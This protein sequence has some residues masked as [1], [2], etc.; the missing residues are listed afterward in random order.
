MTIRGVFFDVDFTLIRPGMMFQGEGYEAF[1]V[2]H[3]I[4]VDRHKFEEALKSAAPLLDG[5]E[6][7]RYDA[8]I[9]VRYTRHIIEQMGGSGSAVD[10]CAREIYNEW[11]TNDHFEMYDDVA[12]TLEVIAA[13]GVKIGLIS[14]SHRCLQSFQHHFELQHVVSGA[15]SSLEHG[16][17]KP[18]A[19]I[20]LAAMTL[21]G[22]TPEESLM[23]GDSLRQD[24]EGGL[25]AGMRGV[26]L[27]RSLDPHPQEHDLLARGVSTIRSLRELPSLVEIVLG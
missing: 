13:R 2:R 4:E 12:E 19:E 17:M 10:A 15:L 7:A 14:N 27:H 1:C 8:E 25:A 21:V 9:Y 20:F 6:D 24:I 23:V 26:F 5:G 18:S 3:G 11:A 22:V 16:M